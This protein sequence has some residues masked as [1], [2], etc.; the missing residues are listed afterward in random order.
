MQPA[1]ATS[2]DKEDLEEAFQLFHVVNSRHL[3]MT[4]NHVIGPLFRTS[5]HGN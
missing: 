4:P 3:R 1:P 2:A 5:A